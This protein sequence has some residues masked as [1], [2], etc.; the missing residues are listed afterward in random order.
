MALNAQVPSVRSIAEQ[1]SATDDQSDCRFVLLL[2]PLTGPFGVLDAELFY[3]LYRIV[4]RYDYLF[5]FSFSPFFT[6][7]ALQL[8]MR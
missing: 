4:L 8:M 7:C 2:A 6:A 3:S 1:N 5:I